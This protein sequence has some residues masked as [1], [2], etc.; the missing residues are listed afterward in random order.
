MTKSKQ[1]SGKRPLQ[2]RNFEVVVNY[3][4]INEDQLLRIS[5][6]SITALKHVLDTT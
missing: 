6:E 5:R 1:G 4:T 3:I 2:E